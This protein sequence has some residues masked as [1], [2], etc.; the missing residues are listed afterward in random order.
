MGDSVRGKTRQVLNK[1]GIVRQLDG[2]F[3]LVQWDGH[4]TPSKVTKHA[5]DLWIDGDERAPRESRGNVDG[6]AA[7]NA[8]NQLQ[9]A[10]D[11]EGGK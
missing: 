1:R 2:R 5:I 8:S 10:S 7:G 4:A 11:E 3:Y 9:D 6:V